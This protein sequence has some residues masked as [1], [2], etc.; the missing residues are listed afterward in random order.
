MTTRRQKI[1]QKLAD[2]TNNV[3]WEVDEYGRPKYTT[4]EVKSKF[5]L[6]SNEGLYYR[7]RKAGA[8]RRKSH[9]LASGTRKDL[10]NDK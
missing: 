7:L 3:Y 4:Q 1:F 5:G 10:T 6:N 9:G 8:G 2:D